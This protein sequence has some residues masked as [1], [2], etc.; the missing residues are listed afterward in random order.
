MEFMIKIATFIQT[1]SKKQFKDYVSIFLGGTCLLIGIIMFWTY[2]KSNTLIDEIKTIEK[3]AKKSIELLTE[4]ERIKRIEGGVRSMIDEHKDFTLKSFFE[5]FC[6]EQGLSPESGWN[7]QSDESN[8][9]Y[10]ETTLPALFKGQTTE[11]IVKTL[12][13]LGKNPMIFIKNVTLRPE[14]GKKISFGIT[15]AT[16]NL[17]PNM[18]L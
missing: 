16:K 15:L 12:I 2:Y 14:G 13:A 18:E 9:N 5:T 7:A 8:P 1:L 17:K 3:L 11:S 4:N 6:K 10:I